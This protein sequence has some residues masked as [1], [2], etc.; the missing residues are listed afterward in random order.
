VSRHQIRANQLITTFGPGA[1]VDF[2][3]KSVIIAGLDKWKYPKKHGCT[4]DEPRLAAKVA[5]L[6][7]RRSVK[8]RLPPPSE[9]NRFVKGELTPGV[10]GYI[11]PH[12]FIVQNV[13]KSP[14][15]H[16]R[17][18]L[19]NRAELTAQSRFKDGE[20][21]HPVVPVRFVR[22]CRSGH[23]G[24]LH[25]RSFA[26]SGSG[27]CNR[28][29]WIE[30]RGTTGDLSDAWIV[31]ECGASRCMRDAAQQGSLGTCNGSRP[32][33]DDH[34]SG[35]KE[36]NL[37]LIRTASNAYFAQMLSV[38]SIPNSISQ[39][40]AVVLDLLDGTLGR[41]QNQEQLSTMRPLVPEMDALKQY[42][43]EQVMAA[44]AEVREDKVPA[45]AKPVKLVEFEKLASAVPG[46]ATDQMN[47]DFHARLM[48][49]SRW[50]APG[51]EVIEKVVMVHRLREVA[52]LIGFTR[53]DPASSD[54]SGELDIVVNRASIGTT[55][56][57]I[58]VS[59]N[60]GEGIFLQFRAEAVADWLAREAV[61]RR[62]VELEASFSE[63]KANHPAAHGEFP[64]AAYIML[65]SL[66]HLLITSIS[67]ECG[68]PL[69]SLRERIYAPAPDAKGMDGC[70]GIL[71]FTS[72]AGSEGTLGGLVHSA[73]DIRR[74]ILKAVQTGSLCSNDPV[75][76]SRGI[77]YGSIDRISGNAC[78]GCLYI[79]ETSCERFNQYLDRCLVVPT[80]EARGCEFL[81]L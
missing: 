81:R 62:A 21:T 69:S 59:E 30:E 80:L 61:V 26:H 68:Y 71:L 50:E 46:E 74:Q 43:D 14:E 79:A 5:P 12:W 44:I 11:F 2:P 15:K 1:M 56:E 28:P 13:E 16:R 54:V 72:A 34:E 25:W 29:L 42:S 38:I 70:Y 45:V 78:H 36:D 51:L 67:M 65:H 48:E 33:L 75:C 35:C 66:A 40:H 63:W 22:A 55:H 24:D 8:L 49:P 4:I 58:P 76:S 52:A 17:R 73:Q 77:G 23:V 10:T 47:A 41:I 39:L 31:C 7:S 20:K 3:D 19:V 64:G 9:E 53:F 60:R 37:L 6:L 32:W 57:W 27:S 18:R